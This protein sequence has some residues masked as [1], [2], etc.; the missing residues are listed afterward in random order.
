LSEGESKATEK[1]VAE[2][3]LRKVAS[4]AVLALALVVLAVG[5]G[6]GDAPSGD[7]PFTQ[8]TGKPVVVAAGDIAGC[9]SK[10]DEATAELLAK[11]DG[12]VV[13]LGDEAYEKGSVENF[14]ECYGPTWGRFK[15]RTL[16]VPGNHEYMTEGAEGYFDYFGDAAGD[17]SEGYYSYD[18]GAWHVVALN[19]NKCLEIGGCHALSGQV[20]WLE[21]D[22]EANEGKA[23][24]LAYMHHPLFTSGMYR[25]GIPEVKPL[26]EV[27]HEAGADVV[28][29]AHDH[30]YQ[31]F[32]PQN[33]DGKVDREGGI[34]EFVV[35]TGG[36]SHYE[37]GD[38][39]P[40]SEVQNDETYGVLKFTLH[41]E[42]Y[43]WRFVP[44]EGEA[45]RDS[46]HG[47]CH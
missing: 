10:G 41:P 19:S 5:C 16:P 21:A 43:D 44:V 7:A 33:P 29:S 30:N 34:R 4:V 6:S 2:T 40:N 37:I 35:G 28:L 18:L 11:I 46:G 25:P 32:A 22:L 13:A 39:L 23:C 14:R 20:R 12:T 9:E 47:S 3:V 31:R 15:D 27:L 1:L 42:G 38:V 8:S 36:K 24:T 17:P 26:W 45:F